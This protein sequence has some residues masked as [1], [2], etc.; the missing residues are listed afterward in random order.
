MCCERCVW[1]SGIE[2]R[3]CLIVMWGLKKNLPRLRLEHRW[4][5]FKEKQHV[6]LRWDTGTQC[7]TSRAWAPQLRTKMSALCSSANRISVVKEKKWVWFSIFSIK[8]GI[9]RI[10]SSITMLLN[11]VARYALMEM[12]GISSL[13]DGGPSFILP[14]LPELSSTVWFQVNRFSWLPSCVSISFEYKAETCSWPNFL[15]VFYLR[16]FTVVSWEAQASVRLIWK[17]SGSLTATCYIGIVRQT[18]RGSTTNTDLRCGGGGLDVLVEDLGLVPSVHVAAHNH[19]QF[20]FH[21]IQCPLLS[22]LD[23]RPSCSIRIYMQAK[24]PNTWNKLI[25]H[26]PLWLE[27]NVLR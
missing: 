13:S 11:T 10:L 27:A 18:W 1:V 26:K 6:V 16:F 3:K 21:G 25:N 20:Q 24:H 19:L 23:T 4:N 5:M 22:S 17:L 12:S 14:I 2:D 15:W 8:L 7:M 9:K